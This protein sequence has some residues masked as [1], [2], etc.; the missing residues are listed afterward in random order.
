MK[1]AWRVWSIHIRSQNADFRGKT[2]CYTCRTKFDWKY[3]LQAGH[4]IHSQLDFDEMNIHPQCVRCNKWLH[5]NLGLYGE[6]LVR[7]YGQEAVDA[8][9][10]RGKRKGNNYKINELEEIIKRYS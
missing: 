9:R 4:Y 5:G 1:E 7:E 2:E 6:R 8:L 3:E 10:I